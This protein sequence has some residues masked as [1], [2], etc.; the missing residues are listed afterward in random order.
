[1]RRKLF[2]GTVANTREITPGKHDYDSYS[3]PTHAYAT[4]D[5][6]QAW[7]YASTSR[8]MN[9]THNSIGGDDYERVYQVEPK[10]PDDVDLDRHHAMDSEQTR[11]ES[12]TGFDVVGET[13]V[14]PKAQGRLFP[15]DGK[16]YASYGELEMDVGRTEH[17]ASGEFDKASRRQSF[18]QD[19]QRTE[20]ASG[21]HQ[22]E[23]P[24]MPAP[25]SEFQNSIVSR[26][27]KNT[28]A[29]EEAEELGLL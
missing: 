23:F 25:E 4:T 18:V 9:K 2:H 15:V 11:F 10:N 13:S 28:E 8:D 14:P 12:P 27:R 3:T 5:E 20:G 22:P 1:M 17:H 19:L 29:V 16:K 24:G 6:N 7:R 26:I 21:Y